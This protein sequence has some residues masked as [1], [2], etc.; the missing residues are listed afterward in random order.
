MLASAAALLAASLSWPVSPSLHAEPSLVWQPSIEVASGGGVRGPWRMNESRWDYVDDATVALDAHGA[1]A[2]AW[3]DQRRKDVLFQVYEPDG[4]GRHG[5]PVDVSRTPA[6]FSW[7]PRIAL[8]PL[9]PNRIFVL[10]QEIVFS[11]GSHGGDILFARSL[12][13][14]ATF[15]RAMNLS[16]SRAG[17]GKGRINRDVWHN[18]SLDLA[19]GSDGKLYAAWTEYVGTLW[20]RR[21]RD[22]GAS[23]DAPVR[24]A[25]GG[26][27]APARAPA[28]AVAADGTVVL[29]WTLGDVAS[30][31]VHV[32]TSTDGGAMF[33]APVIVA[34]TAGYSDAPKLAVDR[35]GT[36]H[37]VVSESAGGPFD[38]HDVRYT[39][40]RDR[41]RTFQPLR[42]LSRPN[43]GGIKSA[44]FPALALD[45]RDNVYVVWELYRDRGDRPRGLALAY[46]IDR[47]ATFSEP[48]LVDASLDPSG[49]SNGSHQGMLMRKLA[50]NG[51]GV[52][53][54]VNSSLV[55]GSRSRV[56]LMRG[57]LQPR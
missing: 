8:S 33:G 9:D 10:W 14:G 44:A 7:L 24:V 48:A 11:G 38:R 40:S 13:G 23:F 45:D 25:G 6:V 15:E 57:R 27:E 17:D 37:V 41:G 31:D 29:A 43:S 28:L 39:R 21:S 2:V 1:A 53:A 19:I 20:F 5:R 36:L 12:D 50:V 49:G 51:G 47:G 18:G 22:A 46:S 52:I 16:E 26:S 42:V 32:A 35:A 54:V 56:W 4:R 3:V 55:D 34:R 30:A